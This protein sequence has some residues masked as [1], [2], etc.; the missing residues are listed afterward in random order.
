MLLRV[1]GKNNI[2]T[3]MSNMGVSESMSSFSPN[4]MAICFD[5][6]KQKTDASIDGYSQIHEHMN[7]GILDGVSTAF[8]FT[9]DED[10]LSM[11][12]SVIVYA[13]NIFIVSMS[14]KDAN[15]SEALETFNDVY[16]VINTLFTENEVIVEKSIYSHALILDNIVESAKQTSSLFKSYIMLPDKTVTSYMFLIIYII[17]S[18]G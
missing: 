11:N 14:A 8:L 18:L 13:K 7:S 9:K 12:G 2:K 10:I 1:Y 17:S 5:K 15:L 16:T 4:D 6:L 3:Y